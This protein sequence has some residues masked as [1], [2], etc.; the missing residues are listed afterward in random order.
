MLGL[1]AVSSPDPATSLP[2]AEIR[3]S[4]F[5]LLIVILLVFSEGI[6][7]RLVPGGEEEDGSALLRLLWLP[8]YAIALFGLMW[9]AF[10]VARVCLRLPFLMLLVAICAASFIWSI[11]P[12]LTQRRSLAIIMTTATGLYMGTRYDWQTLLRALGLAWFI[13]AILAFLTGA[14]NPSFGRMQEVHIGAW[15]GLYFEKNQL[16]GA[17]AMAA[18]FAGFLAI[19]DRKYRLFWS[20]FL[21]LAILL[22]VLST[23]KTALLGLM[24]GL[25]VLTIC[26]WMKRGIATG[27]ITLWIGIIGLGLAAA[28][29]V[30]A[31]EVVFA[32][33]GRDMTLT[34]RTDIW[35]ALVDYIQQRPLL[36]YG[37]GVFWSPDSGPGNWVR[38]TLEWDAPTAHNGW[39]EVALSLGLIGLLFLALDF[40]MTVWR[41]MMAAINMWVGVFALGFLAQFFLFSLSESSSLQQNSI[42]WVIYVA[43]AAKLAARPRGFAV[44]K[45]A[46][47][48]PKMP[49]RT[50][51]MVSS[52]AA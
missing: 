45:P 4:E 18:T 23:S 38:E 22:V 50:A 31:P 34:G 27:L 16:G 30:F 35:I 21:G 36:G 11:E 7:P 5:A 43:I 10:D 37:Y 9:K 13:I 52:D 29:L 3:W 41:A 48:H 20:G 47:R 8:I 2:K 25:G 26:A 51:Q 28:V 17:M 19:M 33:L 6:L 12:S 24:L 49:L 39:L 14:L 40:L 46:R 32:V 15:Q 1:P 42:V 44:T